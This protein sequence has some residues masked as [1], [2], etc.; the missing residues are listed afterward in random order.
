MKN[1]SIQKLD[2][3]AQA[4]LIIAIVLTVFFIYYAGYAIGKAY[5]FYTHNN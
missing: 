4:K 3:K 1:S 5:F 2:N